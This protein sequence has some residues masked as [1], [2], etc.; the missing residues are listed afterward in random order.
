MEDS[1][2]HEVLLKEWTVWS[3]YEAIT[4][5]SVKYEH[6][7]IVEADGTWS[8]QVTHTLVLRTPTPPHP[9]GGTD[10]HTPTP[11]NGHPHPPRQAMDTHTPNR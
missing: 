5:P 8:C 1:A 9:L 3:K 10:T 7:V 6:K 11:T 2:K 4:A